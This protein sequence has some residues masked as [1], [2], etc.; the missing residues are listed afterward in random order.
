MCFPVRGV[1][2]WANSQH[3]EDKKRKLEE[4]EQESEA[5]GQAKAE[6]A[7]EVVIYNLQTM[8]SSAQFELCEA[9][10]EN[11]RNMQLI[12]KLREDTQKEVTGMREVLQ[13]V[14]EKERGA[15]ELV[16]ELSEVV[17][18]QKLRLQKAQQDLEHSAASEQE[19]AQLRIEVVRLKEKAAALEEMSREIVGLKNE[20]ANAS[21]KAE[22][23]RHSFE[24][25]TQLQ[26]S[27]LKEENRRLTAEVAVSTHK[28][29]ETEDA[30]RV[31]TK[32]LDSQND[33]IAGLKKELVEAKDA[34]RGSASSIKAR[35]ANWMNRLQDEVE[36]RQVL[37]AEVMAQE[38]TIAEMEMDLKIA[39]TAKSAA[40]NTCKMLQQKVNDMD[41]MLRYVENEIRS[42]KSLYE[43]REKG[44]II[45]RDQ[46]LEELKLTQK[47][48]EEAE[49][50]AAAAIQCQIETRKAMEAHEKSATAAL[51]EKDK[52]VAEA[53][54][55]VLEIEAEMH[56][57]ISIL[58]KKKAI[59]SAQ[60]SK[61][62][63]VLEELKEA[64]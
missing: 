37:Q 61:L 3:N 19:A 53:S 58:E 57:R 1:N 5:R 28:L 40:E 2:N 22:R 16:T 49:A 30:V 41:T 60:V 46:A 62:C 10:Q 48:M 56:S 33:T 15:E 7:T 14:R 52:A 42:V 6:K 23:E 38:G 20:L 32:M 51:L 63:N 50:K 35:D 31:K 12:R 43:S 64:T 54:Q 59:S 36:Q 11:A 8:L 24:Q 44:V 21:G 27:V 9:R 47:K 55:K 34:A 29:Q 39:K 45:Q 4:I 26:L 17:R 13:A 25:A 18:S